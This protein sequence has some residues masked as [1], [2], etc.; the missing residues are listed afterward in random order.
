MAQCLICHSAEYVSMQ[1]LLTR[2][3]WK[4]TVE[5][6]QKKFGAPLPADQVDALVDYIVKAYGAAPAP[7][8]APAAPVK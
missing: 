8:K 4:A 7:V 2:T 1:P 3:A 5:K 6:M